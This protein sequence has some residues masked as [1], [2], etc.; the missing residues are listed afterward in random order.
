M[1]QSRAH[2]VFCFPFLEYLSYYPDHAPEFGGLY[3]LKKNA[4]ILGE[5]PFFSSTRF[6]FSPPP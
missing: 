5:P 2:T 6:E 3:L 1:C 4:K